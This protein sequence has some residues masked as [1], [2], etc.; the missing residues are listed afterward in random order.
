MKKES[1]ILLQRAGRVGRA[2][3]RRRRVRRDNEEKAARCRADD[4]GNRPRRSL[5]IDELAC[6]TDMH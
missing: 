5:A 3:H 1:D 2:T 6:I 4:E